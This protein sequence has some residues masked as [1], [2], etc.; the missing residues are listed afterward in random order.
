MPAIGHMRSGKGSRATVGGVNMRKTDWE[1]DYQA[2]DL[3]T[4]NFESAGFDQGTVGIVS[5]PWTLKGCW[6][7]QQNEY[8]DPPGLFP[9]D[10]L[11]LVKLYTSVSDNVFWSL[12]TN[13][14]ISGKNSTSV[15]QL[16]MF[17]ASCKTNGS[18]TRPTGSV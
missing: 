6:D 11:G 7:A 17:E 3:D 9:R 4:T 18:F 16:V 15:K 10:D 5:C 12:P 13:R 2:D 1:A 8:D 14:V